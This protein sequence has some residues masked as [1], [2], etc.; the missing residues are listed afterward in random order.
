MGGD[1]TLFFAVL[2]CLGPVLVALMGLLVL[3]IIRGQR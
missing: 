2:A 1:D 3:I